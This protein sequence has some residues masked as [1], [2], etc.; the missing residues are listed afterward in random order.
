MI[1]SM[2]VRLVFLMVVAFLVLAAV[3]ESARAH[4]AEPAGRS[5]SGGNRGRRR[6]AAAS[7]IMGRSSRA[8]GS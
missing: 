7:P 3:R 6:R 1:A 8:V 5:A 4:R 2:P